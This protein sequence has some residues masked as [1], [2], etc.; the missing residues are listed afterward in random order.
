MLI[1]ALAFAYER[2]FLAFQEVCSCEVMDVITDVGTVSFIGCAK[3]R[4]RSCWF[5]RSDKIRTG[6]RADSPWIAVLDV[7]FRCDPRLVAGL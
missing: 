3:I 4:R 6:F 2:H 5:G 1:G 7:R